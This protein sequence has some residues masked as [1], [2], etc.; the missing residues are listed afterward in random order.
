MAGGS[1]VAF[2]APADYLRAGGAESQST[3]VSELERKSRSVRF[4]PPRFR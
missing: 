4:E 3:D 1:R 2:R